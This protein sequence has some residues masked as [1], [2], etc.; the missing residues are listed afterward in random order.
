MSTALRAGPSIDDCWNRIGIT[1]D[2][3]CPELRTH[4]HCRSCPVFATAARAFFDRPAP[5]GYLADCTQLLAHEKQ[6]AREDHLTVLLFR[7]SSEWLALI[8]KTLAEVS[9][10]RPV[11]RIPHNNSAALSG[12]VS[13][14][15]QLLPCLSLHRL[16]EVDVA[17]GE[18]E[19]E[20]SSGGHQASARLVVMEKEGERWAFHADEVRG[21]QSVWQSQLRAVPS[22]LSKIA[23]SH[24]RSVFSWSDQSVG[25]LDELR[26]FSALGSLGQ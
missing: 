10:P 16:L 26:L 11:H 18:L 12:L 5:E 21:V 24:V 1:G 22:T 15:G 17:D 6:A 13:V 8:A 25:L 3:T 19:S 7:L 20:A 14:R 2:A 23:S 4:I 9:H